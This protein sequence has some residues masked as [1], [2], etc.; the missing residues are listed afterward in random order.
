MASLVNTVTSQEDN[1][2]PCHQYASGCSFDD[3]VWQQAIGALKNQDHSHYGR[4][5]ANDEQVLFS[6]VPSGL[7]DHEAFDQ[8]HKFSTQS[9]HYS[10]VVANCLW[11]L[12]EAEHTRN[13]HLE[14]ELN[15][16]KG[17]V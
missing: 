14:A 5:M 9:I 6:L 12:Y 7:V 1:S 2:F 13:D 4:D 17:E 8:P 10:T 16:L 15:T 11:A 3:I